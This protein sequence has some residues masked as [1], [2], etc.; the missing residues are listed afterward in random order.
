[1]KNEHLIWNSH[2]GD[3]PL[4]AT[5]IHDGH[6]LRKEVAELISLNDQEQ[7][8]EEDPFTGE[9]AVIAN[10]RII[11]IR[12][13]FEVDLNRP[14][15]KAVYI[16]PEDAWGLKVWKSEPSTELVSRS[17]AQYDAFYNEV[18]KILNEKLKKHKRLVVLDLHSYNHRREGPHGPH[19]YPES[20]PE[21]NIG[22]GTMDRDFW[23]RIVDPFISDL[24][25]YDFFARTLDVRENVKFKGGNF[26]GWIHRKFPE[27]VCSIAV[28]FKKFFMDEWTGEPDRKQLEKITLALQSTIPG[29]LQTLKGLK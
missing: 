11:G 5:A 18:Y 27:S 1:M 16:K 22:T 25:A 6:Q 24:R 7:L 20:N 19:A 21:V 8:R 3:G 4:I 23:A 29:I 28:E 2:I 17:L 14:R 12:S 13:R 26:S 9:W 15:D 10:T